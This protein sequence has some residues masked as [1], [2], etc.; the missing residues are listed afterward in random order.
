MLS[1]WPNMSYQ[2]QM[3]V[4]LQPVFTRNCMYEIKERP[5]SSNV[6]KMMNHEL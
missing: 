4:C 2:I 5:H 1:K 3:T 6:E